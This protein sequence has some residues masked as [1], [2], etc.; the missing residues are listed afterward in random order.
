MGGDHSPD[1]NNEGYHGKDGLALDEEP[2]VQIGHTGK[3][4]RNGKCV[5]HHI[6]LDQHHHDIHHRGA[7]HDQNRTE[8]FVL[9]LKV[10]EGH[11][12][13]SRQAE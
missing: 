11:D 13:Q 9:K 6:I 10:P 8:S 2:Q 1:Q 4:H 12:P 7:K 3:H 5:K